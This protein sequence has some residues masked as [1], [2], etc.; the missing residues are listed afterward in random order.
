LI[1]HP[2]RTGVDAW[3]ISSRYFAGWNIIELNP[4]R[5]Q[6]YADVVNDH[7][8]VVNNDNFHRM[9]RAVIPPA[10]AIIDAEC[11]HAHEKKKAKSPPNASTWG[12]KTVANNLHVLELRALAG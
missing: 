7:L 8:A 11:E 4:L 12:I 3:T 10:H 5:R 6:R 9:D 2:T 1:G